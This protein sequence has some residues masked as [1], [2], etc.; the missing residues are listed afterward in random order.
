MVVPAEFFSS[1]ASYQ[2]VLAGTTCHPAFFATYGIAHK[3]AVIRQ[4]GIAN[5]Y[6]TIFVHRWLLGWVLFA[7]LNNYNILLP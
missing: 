2:N 5:I 3:G 6:V 4:N 7:L 1:V